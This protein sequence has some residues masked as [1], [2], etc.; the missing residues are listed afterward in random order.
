MEPETPRLVKPPPRAPGPSTLRAFATSIRGMSLACAL[1]LG[2]IGP[3]LVEVV[4]L[5]GRE[6]LSRDYAFDLVVVT[7]V[8]EELFERLV[9]GA[10][11]V[12]AF[13]GPGGERAVCGLASRVRHEAHRNSA[14]H[15][16]RQ[17]RV[18]LSPQAHR[19]H[20]RKCTRI[21][22]RQSADRVITAVCHEAR[23][24]VRFRLGAALPEREY[25][26]QYEETDHAFVERLAAEHGLL[27]YFVQPF[28]PA[29]ALFAA[30]D[31]GV[32]LG[33]A[34][35]AAELAA[36]AAGGV[37]GAALGALGVAAGAA[38]LGEAWVFTDEARYPPAAP[39]G[40][41]GAAMSLGAPTGY[42]GEVMGLSLDVSLAAPSIPYR[43]GGALSSEGPAVT[44]ATLERS[45]RPTTAIHRVYDPDRP[46]VPL[47]A[48]RSISAQ[49]R[50]P[51]A[52][53]LG[54]SLDL[55][56]APS[57]SPPSP[58]GLVDDALEPADLVLYEHEGKD[59]FPAWEHERGEP[60]RA[61][62]RARR[63]ARRVRGK[64][65]YVG[66]EAG[67]RFEL[68]EH[69]VQALDRELVV[70]RATHRMSVARAPTERDVPYENELVCV[71]ADVLWAPRVGP[72]R[73]VQVCLTA[74]VV[75]PDGEEIHTDAEGRVQVR[76]H[77][78]RRDEHHDTT[79]WLRC[80]QP[81]ASAGWGFQFVPRVGM[82]AVVTFENGDPDKPLVLGTL[83][84]KVTP[85]PFP[86]PRDKTKS[87]VKTRSTPRSEGANELSFEDAAGRERIYLHAERDLAVDVTNE[88]LAKIGADDGTWVGGDR[89]VQVRGGELHEVERQRVA[90]V[91]GDERV[92]I[93]GGR[94]VSVT[95][96]HTET[97]AGDKRTAVTGDD[98]R[99]VTGRASLEAESDVVAN[100]KGSVAFL[101]GRADA[102]RA[103]SGVVEGPT[104]LTSADAIQLRS[105]KEIVL[106]V[107]SS[108][109]RIS[110]SG[111][112]IGGGAI[113]LR[114][115]DA[116][117]KLAEGAI[118]AKASSAIQ[119]I[120]DDKIVFVSSGA[121]LQLTGDA[122]LS[123]S[124]IL[125]GSA[126]QAS[127]DESVSDPEPATL[128]V[129]DQDGNP[130]PYQRFV[131]VADDAEVSG[132]LDDEGKAVVPLDGPGEL[133]FPDL[134]EVEEQ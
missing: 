26:T 39:G 110:S 38:R 48:E 44:V 12:L 35:S 3:S 23:V 6:A 128:E 21:F 102:K 53:S 81:W 63:A 76:F 84:N 55:S 67:R 18:R 114:A 97:V 71:P 74:T 36:L 132:F 83:Y 106:A 50:P 1:Q 111:V 8:P 93:M 14:S 129:T 125:L 30:L 47:E 42:A 27:S 113:A 7:T 56:G 9:L 78:D 91:R 68:E 109:V 13:R 103:L 45:V 80:M 34:P 75:G 108:F 17:F 86:L 57:M 24:D 120:S 33:G 119:G 85:T 15:E 133:M 131:I 90:R 99:R 29:E 4:A 69:P 130:V 51:E 79:C 60:K 28:G 66:V 10:P 105:D 31:A 16:H 20:H 77:W 123:G 22:Q 37:A 61:L 11:A 116:R 58:A 100:V 122:T 25:L 107:G 117:I 70:V 104:V 87:G 96:D 40:A 46:L 2:P 118:K 19:L 73:S 72:R 82:E 95:G 54:L 89:T 64:S 88:R 65:T 32:R 43:E 49:R 127:D 98:H 101:V 134:A 112:D 52:P 124:H 59:L 41:L 115:E 62:A 92:E 94:A 5:E 121:S 126:A